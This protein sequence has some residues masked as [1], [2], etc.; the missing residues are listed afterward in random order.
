MKK[1]LVAAAIAAAVAAP[2]ANAGVVIYG[3]IHASIDYISKDTGWVGS[4]PSTDTNAWYV[5]N[6]ASRIGF[7]GT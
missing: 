4:E 3:K 6:R 5:T 1:S 7:K 2:A